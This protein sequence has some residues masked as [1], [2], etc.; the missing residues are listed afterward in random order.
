MAG[1][2]WRLQE[3]KEEA[4]SPL[5]RLD[6]GLAQCS[7]HHTLPVKAAMGQSSFTGSEI[8]PTAQW[9]EYQRICG[10]LY[11]AKPG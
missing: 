4:V 8:D 7:F 11:L 10:H 3:T 6:L 1:L 5:Q 9:E 2:I